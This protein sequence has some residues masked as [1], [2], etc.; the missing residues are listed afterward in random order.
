MLKLAYEIIENT[1]YGK[2]DK[3]GVPYIY[4]LYKVAELVKEYS[5][6]EDVQIIA[7]FHDLIE[8]FP[9]LW[10]IEKLRALGFNERICSALDLLT[11]KEQ[12]TYSEYIFSL[13]LNKDAR[14]VKKADLRHN[15]DITRFPKF[16]KINMSLLKRY[17]SS[18]K[19]I[20]F[21]DDNGFFM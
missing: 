11:R 12:K 4:H 6:E 3:N 5:D 2:F 8:D 7:L 14:D 9:D 16:S 1:F 13:M 19:K 15:M 20:C 17:H 10:S 18:F 21:Y